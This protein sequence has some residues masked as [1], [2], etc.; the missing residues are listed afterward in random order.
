MKLFK[1]SFTII[2]ILGLSIITYSQTPEISNIKKLDRYI[3]TIHS[4]KGFNGEI[5]IA[6][7]KNKLFQKV[8]GLASLEN[9]LKLEEG[10][11]YKIASISKTF[12]GALIAM[13]QGD[14]KLNVRDKVVDYVDEL[15][16]RFKD[17]TIRQL[18]NHTSGLPH[19]EGIKD[20]WQIKSKLSMST[21]DVLLE[22]NSL[23][24][25][26]KP[27]SKMKYSS[28]GYYLLSTILEKVYEDDFQNI[29]QDKILGK[30]QMT[31]TGNVNTL[32]I[33]PRMTSGYHLVTD[34]S[35]VAAPYR[36]YSMLKGA[37]DI[38]SNTADLLKW[39]NSILSGSLLKDE[40]KELIFGKPEII[41]EKNGEGYVFGWYISNTEPIKYFHGGGTWGYS[42]YTSIYPESKISIII[43]CNVSTLP[44]NAIASA[45]EK[46][47]FGKLFEMPV[48]ENEISMKDINPIIYSG[49]FISES[50][51]MILMIKEIESKLYAQLAGRPPFQIYPKGNHQFFG[52]KVD[53]E[54]SFDVKKNK[55]FGLSAERMGKV[56]QFNKERN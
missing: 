16:P 24:L 41:T 10:A 27:G 20:Y 43:L 11:E 30:L 45:I 8:V 22:I 18:L 6:K 44:V 2:L 55:V 12:T 39:N 1:Q 21:E 52:K 15:S 32:K 9:N 25:L 42:T 5:L 38:Y 40:T 50:G 31:K 7:G 49:K 23:D 26:F 29:L 35:L 56:F 47:V 54:F 37:G 53:V 34:D 19:N 17:I 46:I 3:N 14:Q 36:N 48:I 33:I 51:K 28:L 13:A 4:Q